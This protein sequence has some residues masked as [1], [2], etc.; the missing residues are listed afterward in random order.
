[1]AKSRIVLNRAGV[2]ALLRM[3]VW[4]EAPAEAIAAAAGPGHKVEVTVGPTRARAAV[5]T[6]TIEAMHA[7][8]T[9]RALTRAIDAGR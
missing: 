2:K 3:P 7:E 9:E 1:M 5:I 6:D 4:V 8:A